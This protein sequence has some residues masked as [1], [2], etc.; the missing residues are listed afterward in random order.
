MDKL[1]L[2]VN[3]V[4]ALLGVSKSKAYQ[5]I[6]DLNSEMA[7]KGYLTVKGKVSKRYLYERCYQEGAR[8]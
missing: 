5:I 6:K 3:D 1:Y 8:A 7:A 2:N 4:M